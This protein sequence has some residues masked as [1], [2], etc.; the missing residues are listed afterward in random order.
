MSFQVTLCQIRPALGDVPRNLGIHRKL[1]HEAAQAGSDLVV[2]PELS[3]TGYFLRDLVPEVG[4][5]LD[6][7]EINQLRALSRHAALVV[8][9]VEESDT[10]DFYCAAGYFEGGRLRHVHRK[11]YLPTYGMFDEKRYLSHG[12]QVRA[13]DTRWGRMAMLVCEDLW[14]PSAVGLAS[15]DR[16]HVLI[17]IASSPGRGVSAA[18][19]DTAQTYERLIATYAQLFQTYVIFVNRVGYEDGVNFWGGSRVVDPAGRTVCELP[20]WEEAIATVEISL[21]EVRRARALEP[22]L[23]DERPDLTAREL[24]RILQDRAAR[25]TGD[26]PP[27]RPEVDP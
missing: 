20:A 26:P 16:M 11:V 9:F 21:S 3:L 17:G 5:R 1:L 12:D 6:S 7:P 27:P 13:F 25:P 24:Q 18:E 19:L 10:F 23:N 14:H 2:F 15:L 4:L 22:R 8:G